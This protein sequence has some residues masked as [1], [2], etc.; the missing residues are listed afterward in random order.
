VKALT[1][2]EL[3]TFVETAMRYGHWL[4]HPRSMRAVGI[5]LFE[6]IDCAVRV[7]L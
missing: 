5:S 7:Q 4:G 3:H 1:P 6:V 2:E